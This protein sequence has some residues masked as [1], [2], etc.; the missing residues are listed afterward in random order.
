MNQRDILAR[1]KRLFLTHNSVPARK[2]N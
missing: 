1:G 2:I